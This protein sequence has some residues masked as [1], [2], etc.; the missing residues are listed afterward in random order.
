MPEYEWGMHVLCMFCHW[1]VFALGKVLATGS[2]NTLA[3]KHQCLL[4]KHGHLYLEL[5]NWGQSKLHTL[6]RAQKF[7]S[8]EFEKGK[9]ISVGSPTFIC[10]RPLR[11]FFFEVTHGGHCVKKACV[12]A[13]QYNFYQVTL[14]HSLTSQEAVGLSLF[15]A[16]VFT[17]S[18]H[19]PN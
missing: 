5:G 9:N 8:K 2:Q 13:I 10:W 4:R 18:S 3:S 6:Y 12:Y 16:F 19:K 1:D 15:H 14:S 11:S 17:P 7:P